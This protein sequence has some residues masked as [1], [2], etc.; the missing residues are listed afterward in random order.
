MRDSFTDSIRKSR[1]LRQCLFFGLLSGTM[2]LFLACGGKFTIK[3]NTE[4]PPTFSLS[5]NGALLSFEVKGKSGPTLWKIYGPKN[6]SSLQEITP[7]KYGEVPPGCTQSIPTNLPPPPL[8]EGEIYNAVG[9]VTDSEAGHVQFT[10]RDGKVTK[11]SK[12]Q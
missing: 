9:I 7:I 8:I 1:R 12:G 11:I 10:I 5:G 4:A 6:H 2:L 3:V